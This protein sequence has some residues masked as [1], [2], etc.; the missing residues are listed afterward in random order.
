MFTKCPFY[1]SIIRAVLFNI[2]HAYN[3]NNDIQKIRSNN[4]ERIAE[5]YAREIVY[6]H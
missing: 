3:D 4:E 6:P 1:T 2:V 5:I